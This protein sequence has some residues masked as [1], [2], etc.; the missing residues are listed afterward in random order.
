MLS[1]A[2][3]RSGDKPGNIQEMR[4]LVLAITRNESN[5]LLGGKSL[6][7]LGR[8]VE[9]PE[10]TAVST[11]TELA[12]LL[13]VHPSTLSR[14][15]RTLGYQGFPEFQ[16]VFREAVTD[17]GRRFYS[18]QAARLIGE[19]ARGSK[20]SKAVSEN[21]QLAQTVQQLFAEST[22]NIQACLGQLKPHTLGV[23]CEHL[24]QAKRVRIHGVRQIYAVASA[25]AY[26]LGLVRPDV[27][28]LDTPEQGV[29]EGLAN[30]AAGDVLLAISVAPYSRIVVEAAAVARRKGVEVV[31]FTDYPNSPLAVLASHC[32]YVP[33]QSSYISNSM[34]AFIVLCESIINMVA[35]R[36]GPKALQVLDEHEQC[37]EHLRI[38]AD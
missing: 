38:Q 34:A 4:E 20:T 5:R 30:M 27:A 12:S 21:E 15:A 19:A 32:F 1:V 22:H 6:A 26:G 9:H 36:L 16:R 3:A 2:V 7:V 31:V 35:R 13:D 28:L 18:D 29:A 25:M 17:Q 24:A 11:I 37:I 33:H 23:V 8:L 14:L 10:Q